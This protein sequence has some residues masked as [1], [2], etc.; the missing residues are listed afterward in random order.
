MTDFR[1]YVVQ[2]KPGQTERA[3]RELQ[4]QGYEVFCPTIKVERIRAGKR[5]KKVEPLFPGYLFI[6]LSELTSNW[7]PIRSTRGVARILIFGDKPAVVPDDVV[8]NLRE[9]M[10]MQ[11]ELHQLEPQQPV[12][13][14]EG[15]FSNLNAIFLE[16][17]GVK[18]ALLLLEMMG[19]WQKLSLPLGAFKP[20]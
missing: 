8:E 6:E 18:R 14:S 20:V 3:A 12:R 4:N 17:D 10:R 2:S 16:Y 11:A 7:R 1:W 15:P 13:I 19:R 9:R 5:V